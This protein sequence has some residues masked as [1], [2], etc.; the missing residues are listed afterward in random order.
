MKRLDTEDN[1]PW[2]KALVYG[3]TGSGKTTLGVTAPKPLI[4]L[5]EAQGA[6]HI[7]QAAKRLGIPVPPVFHMET[8]Q[9]FR[10]W[11]R[12]LQGDKSQPLRVKTRVK[13]DGVVEDKVVAELDEWPETVV[14]DSLSDICRILVE[15]IRRESPPKK[16]TDGLPVDSQRFWNVLGDRY[17][18]LVWAFRDL[19]M[20]TLFL[21][22]SDEREEGDEGNRTRVLTADLAMKKLPRVTAA[23]VN[24][25]AYAFRRETRTENGVKV[26]YGVMTAGP[27]HML[28]KPYRPLRDVE[29]PNFGAWVSAVRGALDVEELAQPAPS[30]ESL[31]A[32]EVVSEE[33]PELAEAKKKGKGKGNA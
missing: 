32:T 6:I 29:A 33:P 19:P 2:F 5:S 8:L 4:L 30:Q 12:A 15:E 31:Q 18:A 26:Q 20:H 24:L 1:E 10:D 25:V 14:I 11:L 7:R 21:A 13:V 27:E 9:D 22:L 17:K 3:S 16:G 23:A 28:L